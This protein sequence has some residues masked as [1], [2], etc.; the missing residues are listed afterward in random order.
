MADKCRYGR[1][2]LKLAVQRINLRGE[3]GATV[4]S[5]YYP[6]S[7]VST[8]VSTSGGSET[9][10]A[11]DVEA[12]LLGTDDGNQLLKEVAM[13]AA[14]GPADLTRWRRRASR[15]HVAAA[16]RLAFCQSKA[17]V[18]FSRGHRMWLDRVGLE[19]ATSEAVALHKAERFQG[20]LV[21]DL[22]AGI[23]GDSLALAR[24]AGVL[25]VDS[26]PDRC[27]RIAWNASVYDIGEQVLPCQSRAESFAIP[28]GAW[29]HIDPD[30]RRAAGIR[31]SRLAS[32]EPGLSFLESLAS[33]APAGAIKLGPASD[34]ATHFSDSRYEIELIS[35]HGECKE[36]TVWF[37]SAVTCRRRATRLPENVT[38]TDRH[39]GHAGSGIVPVAPISTYMYDTDTALIRAG[40]LDSFAA[41]HGLSRIASGVDYLT[42]ARLVETPFLS[43]F[44]V[45]EVLPFDLKR[46]TGLVAQR[47]LGPL[48][49]KLRGLKTTA[50]E[51]R[52]RL[53]PRGSYPG[54][55]ILVGGKGRAR[56]ILANRV[57]KP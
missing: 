14:P 30:R 13:V 23:G 44:K 29:V 46:L 51:I 16:L 43:T 10:R 9:E 37:G 15:V 20:T 36:A 38:W 57:E 53:R 4:M 11:T 49:I 6:E 40:L 31:A 21:V 12:W 35:L 8:A 54:T 55:L 1:V 27:R 32:Y 52:S 2:E 47:N 39:A 41:A 5:L 33:R 48:E 18:K 50:E 24:R 7:T 45:D 19:Q 26:N 3:R 34:F 42:G 22:C 28:H 56:A 17:G 25:A